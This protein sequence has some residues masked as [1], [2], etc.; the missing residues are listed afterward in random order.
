M[1]DS[2][3]TENVSRFSKTLLFVISCSPFF[4]VLIWSNKSFS[5]ILNCTSICFCFCSNDLKGRGREDFPLKDVS[6]LFPLSMSKAFSM[7]LLLSKRG[8][9][10]S[11]PPTRIEVVQKESYNKSESPTTI[12]SKGLFFCLLMMCAA[13]YFG[14][15]SA[16]NFRKISA[17]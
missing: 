11:F 5:L 16:L 8:I 17:G 4:I 10:K 12:N 7:K 13:K 6:A 3:S 15:L 9:L 2:S 14:L 1:I